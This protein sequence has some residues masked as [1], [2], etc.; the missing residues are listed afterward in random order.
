[1]TNPTELTVYLATPYSGLEEQSFARVNE[2]SALMM[3]K[4][5]I[6]F[7]PISHSHTISKDHKI[8]GDWKFWKHHDE[9]YIERFSDEVWVIDDNMQQVK[10]SIGVQ[11]EIEFANKL[12]KPVKYLSDIIDSINELEDFHG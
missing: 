12:G 9:V 5:I 1:M 2:V 3:R 10:D 8:P 6:I 7:S 4:G 11:A